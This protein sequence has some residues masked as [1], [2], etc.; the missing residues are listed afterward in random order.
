MAD[1]SGMQIVIYSKEC[2][3]RYNPLCRYCPPIYTAG[4]VNGR[5]LWIMGVALPPQISGST[6]HIQ[7]GGVHLEL[8]VVDTP[9]FGDIVDNSNWLVV[10]S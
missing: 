10:F 5:A 3:C 6:V 1:I 8:T 7:E 2:L 4:M 9:G